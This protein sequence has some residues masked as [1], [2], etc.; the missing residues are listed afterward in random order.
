[1]KQKSRSAHLSLQSTALSGNTRAP[2]GTVLLLREEGIG[3]TTHS[4][5]RK[6]R[7]PSKRTDEERRRASS[8]PPQHPEASQIQ[9]FLKAK[10]L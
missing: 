3:E 4:R 8:P 9:L 6:V 1:M 7:D 5:W 10:R 2:G